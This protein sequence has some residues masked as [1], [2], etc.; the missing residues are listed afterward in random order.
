MQLFFDDEKTLA[1]CAYSQALKFQLNFFCHDRHLR[2]III[3]HT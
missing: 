3:E 1:S 2:D